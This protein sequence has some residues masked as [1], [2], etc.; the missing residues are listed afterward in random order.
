MRFLRCRMEQAELMQR[1]PSPAVLRQM[2]AKNEPLPS[3]P[4]EHAIYA[5]QIAF[6]KAAKAKKEAEQAAAAKNGGGEDGMATAGAM[7]SGDGSMAKS[8]EEMKSNAALPGMGL[9][10]R[11]RPCLRMRSSFIRGWMRC[12]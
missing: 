3:D 9:I 11:R 1:Y 8:A 12:G 6:Y 5:D 4:V 7:V 2:I 10:R